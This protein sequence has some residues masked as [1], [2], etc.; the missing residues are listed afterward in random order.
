MDFLHLAKDLR[1][2]V[3]EF[4]SDKLKKEDLDY[5]LEA[6]RVSPTACNYQPQRI[7]VID[8]E[9]GCA[10]MRDCTHWPFNAPCY[11][12]ICYDKS[13]CW[14]NKTNGTIGG[15]VD[16]S[17]VTTHMILAAASIGVGCTWVGAVNHQKAKEYFNIPDFLVPVALLPMG[18]PADTAEPNPWHFK[19]FPIEHTVFYNTFDGIEE[20]EKH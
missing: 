7:L 14:K 10:K 17:I 19:R 3:R 9:E 11:L 2:C 16:A 15:D 12:L 13:T 4:K 20:G 1:Y 18:Y 5:I 8:T 6:G